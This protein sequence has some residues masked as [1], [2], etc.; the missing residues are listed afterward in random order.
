MRND[1]Y[2]SVWITRFFL[3][4]LDNIKKLAKNT[5]WSYNDTFRLL[6]PFLAR[7]NKKHFDQLLIPD[8]K[9]EIIK[10]FLSDLEQTRKCSIATRNVRLSCLHAFAE[11]V[12]ISCPRYMNWCRQIRNIPFKKKQK[13]TI[14]PL[15]DSEM[16]A[17]LEAPNKQTLLGKRDYIL[18]LFM[19]NTGARADEVANVMISD[20][21]IPLVPKRNYSSV[22]I[23][24]KGNK[25]RFCPLW[26][27]TVNELLPFIAG[28]DTSQ[29]VFLN[30]SKNPL[31]RFGIYT[32][33]KRYAIE[34]GKQFPAVLQK[35]VSPHTIRHTT[36][37][38]LLDA[39]VD[40]ETVKN[41]LG[42]ASFNSTLIYTDVSIKRKIAA[43]ALSEPDSKIKLIDWHTEHNIMSFL[44][45]IREKGGNKNRA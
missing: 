39:G 37:T 28:R 30:R 29:H 40:F 15:E 32:I 17:M 45:E 11:F 42:H 21:S 19:S 9:P 12:G 23:R 41:W 14:H 33:V 20:L 3:E 2:L 26:E 44:K 24:G 34:I 7:K 27:R 18:L 22:R 13:T 6:L 43:I 38:Q 35:R 36:A 10:S 5:Q 31:T 8:I 25:E 16:N 4:Y 1:Q